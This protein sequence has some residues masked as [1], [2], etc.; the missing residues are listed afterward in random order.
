MYL[1]SSSAAYVL[2]LFENYCTMY[3][4]KEQGCALSMQVMNEVTLIS[5]EVHVRW[6]QEQVLWLVELLWL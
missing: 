4:D 1:L 2:F 6:V 3:Y 5:A